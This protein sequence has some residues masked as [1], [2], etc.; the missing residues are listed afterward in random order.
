MQPHRMMRKSCI[1]PFPCYLCNMSLVTI[2]ND[3]IK[4][5]M[6]SRDEARL[7]ALRN[8]KSAFLLLATSEGGG[9]V[10]DDMCIKALQ[11]MAKQR[12]DSIDVFR[13]QGRVDLAEKEEEELTVI[14]G[15][16]PAQMGVEEVEAAIREIIA[17][18]GAQG[19]KD[20]GKVM[21]VAMKELGANADGKVISDAVKRL[22]A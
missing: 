6:K 21:P 7:R 9:E 18:S 16:L 14:D 19:M 8:I 17:S 12:R 13:Q 10:T 11:K 2:V 4:E 20:M 1:F 3:G 15:F 5:A 22:L